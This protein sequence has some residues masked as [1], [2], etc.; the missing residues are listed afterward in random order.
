MSSTNRL[1]TVSKPTTR[2]VLG[3]YLIMIASHRAKE[4]QYRSVLR[5][6]SSVDRSKYLIDRDLEVYQHILGQYSEVRRV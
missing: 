6:R 2:S 5:I 4:G 3:V 1:K